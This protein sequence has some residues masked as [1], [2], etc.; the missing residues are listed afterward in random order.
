MLFTIDVGNTNTVLGVFRGEELVANW[1]LTTAR[2]Q[3]VDEYG[4][5]TRNLFTLAGLDRDAIT[6]VIISSVV[7]PVNWTL[8]EMSRV[9]F[10]KK[11]LFVELG[12]KTGMAVLVDN[13]SEVGAD[14]IVNGV[15][16]FH[17]YAGPCIVGD[18][19]TAITFDAISAKGEYLGGVIAP[20]LGIS[21]EALFARA[22]RL[23]RVEIKDPGKVIGTN[24]VT[25]MQA[26]LYYGAV[27][28][29]D[30]MLARMK[31]EL[32]ESVK[33][34]ATGGQARLVA[35]GSKHIEHTD[36]FL[37]LTGLRLIWEKNQPAE[38]GKST[39]ADGR[40]VRGTAQA[41]RAQK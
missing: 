18:F 39:A 16:A 2:E 29:V 24:T 3:T 8:A 41:K 5:L 28:M 14:R 31:K 11:A 6:G 17:K 32:G 1:R 26:G 4:V 10:G 12:V 40:G 23:P 30:G 33:V 37:T 25:H 22:A 13:P 38:Q 20:G 34:V 27:D 19:G 36:D 15:A 21:S 9:Y 35:K 7:P